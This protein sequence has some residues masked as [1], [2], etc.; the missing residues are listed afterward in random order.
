MAS[1]AAHSSPAA[2]AFHKRRALLGPPPHKVLME[3]FGKS[4]FLHQSVNLSFIIT[5]IKED[6]DEFVRELA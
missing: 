5:I 2:L 1:A 6:V 4:Q 3:S